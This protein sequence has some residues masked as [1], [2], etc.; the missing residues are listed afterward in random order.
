MKICKNKKNFTVL[1]FIQIKLMHCAFLTNYKIKNY[2]Y[3][4]TQK[5]QKN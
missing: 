1:N 4:N 5:M 2:F 3:K